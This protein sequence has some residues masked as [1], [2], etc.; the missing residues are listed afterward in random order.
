MTDAIAKDTAS[1]FTL[2]RAGSS[3]RSPS[4]AVKAAARTRA[5]A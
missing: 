2:Q 3:R 4:A 1:N 5:A